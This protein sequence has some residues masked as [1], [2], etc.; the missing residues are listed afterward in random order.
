M[1]FTNPEADKRRQILEEAQTI[2]V[3][4]CSNKPDRTSYM[5]AAA[6]QHAGYR[7][8]PVNPM[9][10]G[11]TVL[12]ETVVGSLLDIKEKVDIVDVF[13]RSEETLPVAQEAVKMEQK[14]GTI[15]LQ[16]GVYNEEVAALAAQ[17]GLNVVMDHC[18]KVDHAILVPRR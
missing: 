14:P 8:I 11:E 15:W 16:Q 7:I 17:N 3:V 18:I 12:G 6:M 2:A 4:G 10:A 1:A 13:R 9:I 5:I